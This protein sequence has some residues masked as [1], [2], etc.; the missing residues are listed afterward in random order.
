MR[1]VKGMRAQ[2]GDPPPKISVVVPSRPRESVELTMS[3]LMQQT[4]QDFELILVVDSQLRGAPWARNRG[5]ELARGDYV[6]FSDN[7]LIWA[8][9]ALQCMLETLESGRKQGV[10]AD[11]MRVG[12]AYP[13]YVVT[14]VPRPW[15]R[16]K[17]RTR[18]PFGDVDWS[19][20][21]L[22]Y[23]NFVHTSSLIA[24]EHV[25]DFDP[26]LERLQDWDLWLR[27]AA[28]HGVKGIATHRV[29]FTTPYRRGITNGPLSYRDAKE[30]VQAKHSLKP[31]MRVRRG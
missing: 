24:R 8:P 5:A 6:L 7:D 25:I 11:G 20:P 2:G 12:Y 4:L 9:D 17:R 27:L 1:P 13:A 22:Q 30:I 16:L 15:Y 10:D 19:W 23:E 3:S 26:S 18:G 28:H 31:T 14:K 21:A 29:L